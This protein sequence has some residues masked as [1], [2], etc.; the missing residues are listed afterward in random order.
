[1]T[2]FAS[3]QAN[4]WVDQT[5]LDQSKSQEPFFGV[6]PESG[7]QTPRARAKRGCKL[8]QFQKQPVELEQRLS[9]ASTERGSYC[10]LGVS[11]LEDR[12]GRDAFLSTV[13]TVRTI[14]ILGGWTKHKSG[15][16]TISRSVLHSLCRTEKRWEIY[17]KKSTFFPCIIFIFPTNF[18]HLQFLNTLS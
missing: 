8:E 14:T 7:W 3:L 9:Q 11:S 2:L 12:L 6:S 10:R 15:T 5:P 18:P 16:Q 13:P 1:M 4:V 17:G